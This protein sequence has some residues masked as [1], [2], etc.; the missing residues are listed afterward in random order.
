MFQVTCLSGLSFLPC[1]D[2]G[3]MIIPLWEKIRSTGADVAGVQT[4]EQSVEQQTDQ[5]V[6]PRRGGCV[7]GQIRFLW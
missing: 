3:R 2:C 1:V 7:D 6:L 5:T 4:A